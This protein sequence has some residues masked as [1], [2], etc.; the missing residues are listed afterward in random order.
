MNE[1]LKYEK[2]L[3]FKDKKHYIQ[4]WL[5]QDHNYLIWKYICYLRN[6]EDKK[7]TITD[8]NAIKHDVNFSL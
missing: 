3:Y 1:V 6:E 4:S 5:T 7:T 2:T 8:S